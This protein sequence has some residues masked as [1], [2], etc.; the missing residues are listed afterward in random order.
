MN[1][2][3]LRSK[4]LDEC[5]DEFRDTLSCWIDEV[6]ALLYEA[7]RNFDIDEVADLHRIEDAKREI[8]AIYEGLY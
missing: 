5:S 6:E 7:L 3:E 1:K 8:E 2:G 4:I